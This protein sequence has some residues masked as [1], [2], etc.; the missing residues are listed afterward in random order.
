MRVGFC[1]PD[2]GLGGAERLVIDAAVELSC[3]GHDVTIY[4]AHHDPH[5]CFS[6]TIDGT[7]K[8]IQ[9]R[10]DWIPRNAFGRFHALFAYLRCLYVAVVMCVESWGFGGDKGIGYDIVF[11][12]QVSA[13]LLVFWLLCRDSKRFFYGHFPDLLLSKPGGCLKKLYR[14]PIDWL[15]EASM[16]FADVVSVNSNFTKEVFGRTFSMLNRKGIVPEVLYPAVRLPSASEIENSE[17]QW[18]AE[19]PED[20][21]HFCSDEKYPVTFL[22]IN[23]FERK[24]EIGL[25]LEAMSALTKLRANSGGSM[26]DC[27]IVI[28]GGYDSRLT[29]NREHLQE[30]RNKASHLG[31][32]ERVRFVTSFT[33]RQKLLLL[34]M[35]D[36]VVYTPPNEH[37]GIVPIEAMGFG[38]I[39][40]ACGSGGPKESVVDGETGLLC[41][42]KGESFALAMKKVLD[43]DMIGNGAL[44]R[45][46]VE[47]NFARTVFGN[48]LNDVFENLT[49]SRSHEKEFEG[50][51]G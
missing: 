40:I 39:V 31:I 1:H 48:K 26:S 15:E 30:L 14:M 22:S 17:A 11:V 42:A 28:A 25:A 9:V 32:A 2:L 34:A 21:S 18:K 41:A 5:R 13:M 29:E 46:H 4:T 49:K 6:E 38:R 43:G 50:E 36:A 37:F 7:L 51:D 44:A 10:G 12:D 20:L 19:L 35:C 8:P 47:Q 24:K 27:N 16:G 33:D 23:R 3:H 45:R